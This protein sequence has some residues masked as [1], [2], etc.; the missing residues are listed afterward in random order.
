MLINKVSLASRV[1]SGF[2]ATRHSNSQAALLVLSAARRP[3]AS[4]WLP[5]LEL[6]G[7]CRAIDSDL[8]RSLLTLAV[9]LGVKP[10]AATRLLW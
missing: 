5:S 6:A 2:R 1:S 4:V 7:H 10:C 8:S 9:G 3:P